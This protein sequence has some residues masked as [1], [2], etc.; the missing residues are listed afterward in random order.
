[1]AEKK[2]RRKDI[3]A[4]AKSDLPDVYDAWSSVE[5]EELSEEDDLMLRACQDERSFRSSLKDTP[6]LDRIVDSRI[7][8]VYGERGEIYTSSSFRF[9]VGNGF[10][11]DYSSMGLPS[12]E[13]AVSILE[14]ILSLVPLMK[15]GVEIEV[16]NHDPGI[17]YACDG[18][19]TRPPGNTYAG[20][21][22][23]LFECSREEVDDFDGMPVHRIRY[24]YDGPGETEY[25]GPV[26]AEYEAHEEAGADAPYFGLRPVFYAVKLGDIHVLFPSRPNGAD[27][28]WVSG[29]RP[30][31][32]SLAQALSTEGSF[33]YTHFVLWRDG[34][35]PPSDKTA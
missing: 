12:S 13:L 4:K 2:P 31:L 26:E 7:D 32:E 22:T 29:I 28:E 6:F 33:P 1:M 30:S 17:R 35:V 9:D 10:V 3:V 24:I 23:L 20:S 18:F 11:L 27:L 34:S 15:D 8:F 21:D 14:T 25:D 5:S 19:K 16:D